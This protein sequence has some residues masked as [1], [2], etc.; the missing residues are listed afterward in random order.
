MGHI[1]QFNEP[2][3]ND[4]FNDIEIDVN[5]NDAPN[6]HEMYINEH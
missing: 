5:T 4:Y 1:D 6:L 3:L 2:Q